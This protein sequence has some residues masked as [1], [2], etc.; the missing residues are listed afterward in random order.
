[1]SQRSLGF[2]FEVMCY[3]IRVCMEG[4][5][6]INLEE[7][8]ESEDLTAVKNL[9]GEDQVTALQLAL[10]SC[11]HT[12]ANAL[13]DQIDDVNVLV[14]GEL[15]GWKMPLL[16]Y[17][18]T[19]TLSNSRFPR[20]A[21]EGPKNDGVIFNEQLNLLTRIIKM[22][23]DMH[24]VDSYGNLAIMRAV[25]D[26]LGIDLGITDDEFD[27]DLETVFALLVENG[28]DP[29]EKTKTRSSVVEMFRNN[30]VLSYIPKRKHH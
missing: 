1:M 27:E 26:A 30:E 3:N 18:I 23:A 15:E 16:H 14:D 2:Y 8:I 29:K 6:F 13:L 5:C 21:A 25:L 17:A 9:T 22:G 20:P 11:K 10:K 4:E 7:I 19:Q 24:A 28:A 12:V